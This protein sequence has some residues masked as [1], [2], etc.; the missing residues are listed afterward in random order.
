MHTGGPEEWQAGQWQGKGVYGGTAL[1]QCWA[2]LF[3]TLAFVQTLATQALTSAEASY[4]VGGWG[5]PL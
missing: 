5:F 1:T 4:L 3:W 2:L